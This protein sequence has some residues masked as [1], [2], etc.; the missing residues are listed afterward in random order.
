[1]AI[2][3]V[4]AE[5][6]QLWQALRSGSDPGARER[7]VLLHQDFARILAAKLYARRYTDEV[8]FGDFLQFALIGL[9]ESVDRY[10]P[11]Y[12]ASF[13][14]YASHRIQGAVL[15]G[16]ES[17]TERNCQTALRQRAQQERVRSLGTAEEGSAEDAFTRLASVAVGLA[18]G[19]M[20]DDVS[21]YQAQDAKYGD[22]AY[23]AVAAR[24]TRQRLL[25]LVD[26]L[27]PRESRV[28][29]HHYLQQVSFDDIAKTME[30]TP[31]RI[32]QLHRRALGLMREAMKA[33]GLDLV[34]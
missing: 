33:E 30:L 19:F 25:H 8:E 34:L 9:L 17:L 32:S 31:G 6:A 27:P 2:D 3:S 1:M 14:T 10:D 26:T 29:R 11:A 23:T 13:R 18:V 5:E 12:G 15:S 4:Q 21:A 20:L 16:L 7:L 28:I 22:N 24:Q